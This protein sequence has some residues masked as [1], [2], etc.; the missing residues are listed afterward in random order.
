MA[1]L[2]N[3]SEFI[4]GHDHTELFSQAQA[5]IAILRGRELRFHFVNEAF[6][7]IFNDRPLK[8]L[9]IREAFPEKGNQ[10]YLEI[11]EEVFVSGVA[12]YA[13]EVPALIDLNNNS[14]LSTCYYN[15]VYTPFTDSNGNIEGVMAFGHDVTEQVAAREKEKEN[16]LRFRNIVEQSTGP[17]LILKGEE[18]VLDVANSALF[19][20][21]NIGKESLGKPFLDILPEMKDQGFHDLLLD[22]YHNGVTHHGNET[23]VYFKRSNGEI[24]NHYFNFIYQPF[25]DIDDNIIGVLIMATDVT[26][27]V[28]AKQKL[29]QSEINFRNMILQAPV[30]ICVL[31]DRDYVVEIANKHMYELWGKPEEDILG[32]PIF[33]GLPEAK[34]Q[35]LEKLLDT[36][37]STGRQFLANE[38]P[39]QLPRNGKIETTYLNF[40]YEPLHA[41]D[42]SI[43]GVIA[44]ANEV[45][46]QV[47]ARK[48]V[49]YA[50]ES[51]RLAIESADLGTY[52]VNL[53]TDELT[54]SHRFNT[55][56]GIENPTT[57]RSIFASLIHPDDLPA[58]AEAHKKSLETGSLQYEARI[59]NGTERWIKI[60]GKV[61]YDINGKPQRLLGVIQDISEQKLFS[62]ELTNKVEERTKELID[63]NQRLERSNEELEQFAYVASHDLQE[64]L[65]KIHFFSNLALE[66]TDVSGNARKYIE[67][68]NASSSRMAGLIRSLLEY[69]RL[70]QRSIQFEETDLNATLKNV[71]VDFELLISQKQAVIQ[72]DELPVING[73][74]LQMN[75][76]IFNLIGNALK[77][78]KRNVIPVIKITSGILP[79]E[80]K[81]EF[82]Q[83][84]PE[85][86]YHEIII[87]DNGIGFNQEYADK[88]FTI[89]QRLNEFSKHGGYGIGL[90]LC[91]K[92]VDNHGGI[93]YAEGNPG[94]GAKFGL[95]LPGKKTDN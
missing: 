53:E 23:Q 32:K 10:T 55:I 64:P 44:V 78:S 27:Q 40:V 60:N 65:R 81:K 71:L 77:F 83:L 43:N 28:L 61:L 50:E 92:I 90:A 3:A 94:Q 19:K 87:S 88:I 16:D 42:G 36:V 31:K 73:I 33:Q 45:T 18:L 13:K 58:R 12:S 56:W 52:E 68:V 41:G 46:E 79:E 21:W 66:Q 84:N 47:L 54:T 91:R 57:D 72:S 29:T 49:E 5:P 39:V 37:Y 6:S 34:G 76:L 67:K 35:G 74:T 80:R 48:K 25:H 7:R 85:T 2:L 24:D 9:P 70:S 93:I 20:L 59:I 82:P 15:L 89:F 69:S 86:F 51:A 4:A 14:T 26:E 38:R 1:D 22:V 63:T 75:Q 11:L 62:Q 30:A 95:I 8:G 17:I